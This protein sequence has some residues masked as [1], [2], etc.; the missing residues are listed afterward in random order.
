MSC[1]V[2]TGGH[3]SCWGGFANPSVHAIS[4]TGGASLSNVSSVSVSLAQEGAH[5]TD[6]A[7]AVTSE[8][9]VWCWGANDQGQLGNPALTDT[10]S[11]GAVEVTDSTGTPLENVVEV[12]VG[13]HHA[14]A[15]FEYGLVVC[16]GRTDLIGSGRAGN[17]IRHSPVEVKGLTDAIELKAGTSHTC[18]RRQTGQVQC[19]GDNSWGQ[20]GV[21]QNVTP[22]S[23]VP[24]NVTDMPAP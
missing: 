16:W 18:V 20:L 14:C 4:R 12:A 11:L 3:V 22:T 19:W 10:S 15:R 2:T 6:S 13:A 1:V 5:P 9:N 24:V 8:G 23:N 21:D 7:C 17:A